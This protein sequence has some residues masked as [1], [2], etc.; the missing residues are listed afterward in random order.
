[1]DLQW[2]PGI[3][4]STRGKVTKADARDCSFL[5]TTSGDGKV[6]RPE[7]NKRECECDSKCVHQ[8][9]H[10]P[11]HI[12]FAMFIVACASE[13]G[14]GCSPRLTSIHCLWLWCL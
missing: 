11:A 13:E 9:P 1:M 7:I 14:D 10:E 4:I 3:E 5:A 6:G 12:G 2:L 8:A